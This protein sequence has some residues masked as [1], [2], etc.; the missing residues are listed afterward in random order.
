MNCDD[1]H[2]RNILQ[3]FTAG[4]QSLMELKGVI[5]GRNSIKSDILQI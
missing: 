4:E 2:F 3:V 5:T 1:L